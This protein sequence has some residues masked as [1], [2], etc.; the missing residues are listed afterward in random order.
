MKPAAGPERR[1][2]SRTERWEEWSSWP[3]LVLALSFVALSTV[4]LA[5][6]N[7]DRT[8]QNW[9]T[10]GML[11][12]WALFL[13]DF[14]VRLLLSDGRWRF[15]RSNLFEAVTLVLPFLRAF[16]LVLYLWRLPALKYSLRHQRLRFILV[17]A[18]LGLIFVYVASTLVWLV[19][20]Q[21]PGANILSFGDAIWWGFSTI[22]T[23]GYGD[24][25]PVTVPGRAIAVGLML[26][27]IIIVGIVTAT[28]MSALTE[29]VQRG[30]QARLAQ[31]GPAEA[32]P[33]TP[34]ADPLSGLQQTALGAV[35]QDRGSGPARR[36]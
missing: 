35:R 20:H 31:S 4:V 24:Y 12:I 13:I 5:D 14:T 28:V 32:E 21:A 25:T 29:Q 3:L 19:E 16:L 23:V 6:N 36:D 7:L 11:L 33:P 9:A 26:G 1:R 34:S 8:T 17:A 18:S 22:A 10:V 27:G 15:V 30:M 2:L